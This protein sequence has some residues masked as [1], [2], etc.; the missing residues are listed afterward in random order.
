M[1]QLIYAYVHA[2]IN[3]THFSQRGTSAKFQLSNLCHHQFLLDVLECN[4]LEWC[5]MYTV[6][7][8]ERYILIHSQLTLY[9][10]DSQLELPSSVSLTLIRLRI[11]CYLC[12][13]KYLGH[14]IIFNSSFD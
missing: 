13:I 11:T 6:M 7:E 3:T 9:T 10:G 8:V 12:P 5:D 2:L 14:I 1:H 4:D